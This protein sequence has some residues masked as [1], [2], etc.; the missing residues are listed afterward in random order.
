MVSSQRSALLASPPVHHWPCRSGGLD[1]HLSQYRTSAAPCRT[2]L[3]GQRK[4]TSAT[5][6]R[7][8]TSQ[9]QEPVQK[10]LIPRVSVIGRDS[11]RS[12]ARNVTRQA[13][14][15]RDQSHTGTDWEAPSQDAWG[16]GGSMW[17]RSARL[18]TAGIR[19][20]ARG[21]FG[22]FSI[23]DCAAVQWEDVLARGAATR[24]NGLSR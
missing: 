17:P 23:G 21:T 9:R 18:H 2:R 22:S 5:S 15:T 14:G 19:R 12:S 1:H 6:R 4:G 13:S 24:A 7:L 3:G 16:P 11:N 20:A 10:A 8:G